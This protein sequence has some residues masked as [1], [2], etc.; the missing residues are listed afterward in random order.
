MSR[1]TAPHARMSA[2]RRLAWGEAIGRFWQAMHEAG[3]I[4]AA[5]PL[6]VVD[7][8]PARGE[9]LGPLLRELLARAASIVGGSTRLRY[10]GCVDGD[11]PDEWS[12]QPE[13][14]ALVDAGLLATLRWT[15]GVDVPLLGGRRW[16]PANP[17]AFVSHDLLQRLPSRLLA[18]HYGRLFEVD[19]RVLEGAA[20]Q[21]HEIWHAI[22]PAQD[23][24]GTDDIRKRYVGTLSS[25]CVCVSDRLACLTAQIHA[26][27]T[28][29][30]IALHAAPGA[31]TRRALRLQGVA[32]TLQ[33][34]RA[35]HVLPVNF[36]LLESQA[37]RMG[38]EPWSGE[39]V[40]GE[41]VHAV[42]GGHDRARQVLARCVPAVELGDVGDTRALAAAM[43]ATA[44]SADSDAALALLR[45]AH[46]DVDV[47]EAGCPA[48]H[49]RLLGRPVRNA[50]GWSQALRAV[51]AQMLPHP[52]TRTSYRNIGLCAM[53]VADWS[54]AMHAWRRGMA[55]QG[56]NAHDLLQLGWCQF[57]TGRAEDADRH[58]QQALALD[59][60]HALA[61]QADEQV[62]A[63]LARRD[64][65]WNQVV[66]VGAD[67][68]LLL[69]PLDAMHMEALLH[70]YRDPQIALM[71]GLPP[72][73]QLPVYDDPRRWFESEYRGGAR[74]DYAVV[75][76]EHGFVGQVSLEV[77]ADDAFF[78][79]WIGT[80]FQ[81]RGYAM[82]AAAALCDF[83][84][85]RGVQHVF[86]SAY[87]D[88]MRSIRALQAIGFEPLPL[89][90]TAAENPRSFF[91]RTDAG[92]GAAERVQAH[93][94][95]HRRRGLPTHF[96][97]LAEPFAEPA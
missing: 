15:P 53:R 36:E 32:D 88:N 91:V 43:H 92:T 27:A 1:P 57:R 62:K 17:V 77:D 69:E 29:G 33:A 49:E 30:Y 95:L 4:D 8:W 90:S 6:D 94:E 51:W 3:Q 41:V 79:F 78:C 38:A 74:R 64:R 5:A 22:E 66:E 76:A 56:V 34:Y 61:L 82:A 58:I 2:A 44:R 97:P 85:S 42:V 19:P 80:D 13:L 84:A 45:R 93:L 59:P 54:L 75:H 70:Q 26:V 86:A 31:A 52:Q 89:R 28:R 40:D 71:S 16:S 60:H 46:F 65:A 11:A 18:V 25:A 67:G 14:R 96:E 63:R 50:S 37:R 23:D 12:G 21:H 9:A 24:A 10:L 39:L 87:S 68:A 47:F 20:L 7:L 73:P 81:G 48:L 83:A 72:L 55:A 35:R